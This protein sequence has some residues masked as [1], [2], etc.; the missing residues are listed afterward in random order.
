MYFSGNFKIFKAKKY[1]FFSCT[2]RL[3]KLNMYHS[4]WKLYVILSFQRYAASV[5]IGLN[6]KDAVKALV[7]LDQIFWTT[8]T[9]RKLK[10]QN[11]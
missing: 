8:Y 1:Y 7:G 9:V 10:M 4:I 2:F 6:S 3:L 11:V 5:V